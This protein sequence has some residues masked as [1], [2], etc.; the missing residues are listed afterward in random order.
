[1]STCD[2]DHTIRRRPR[3][4][5]AAT[6]RFHTNVVSQSAK[7]SHVL[8]DMSIS[9]RTDDT[10]SRLTAM[11]N[12][13]SKEQRKHQQVEHLGDEHYDPRRHQRAVH[14]HETGRQGRRAEPLLRVVGAAE[15]G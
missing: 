3:P 4:Q 7:R 2:R 12:R 6:L 11:V 8:L 1:M 13:R 14:M 5:P 10:I 15:S 9:L